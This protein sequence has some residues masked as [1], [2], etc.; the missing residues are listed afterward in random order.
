MNSSDLIDA[1]RSEVFDQVKPYLWSDTEA[2]RYAREA[3]RMFVRKTGGVADITSEAATVDIV[4][5]EAFSDLHPSILRIMSA[6]RQS[7]G[8]EIS[9]L[10]STDLP[11]AGDDYGVSSALRMT[12][13]Q[14][15]VHSAVI[16]LQKGKIRWLNVP[17][18]ND[19][20]T[21]HI[22]RTPLNLISDFDQEITDV[23]EDHHNALI[24]WMKHLCYLKKDA[25]TFSQK[26]SDE[27]GAH[28]EAYCAL[29][30][31]EWE[32][33]KHKTRTVAYGGL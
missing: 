7:D 31:A 10:N 11:V 19:A 16:G 4:A 22:Y 27:A 25:E 18:A 9:I 6:T 5:G 3:H 21:L 24:N 17:D 33:Y 13:Q 23:D 26:E 1:W 32:R 8:G 20:A 15:R 12:T 2:L 14:G 30:K 28:F 29:V